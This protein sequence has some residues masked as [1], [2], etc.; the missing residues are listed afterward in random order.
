MTMK[1]I[2]TLGILSLALF[3]FTACNEGANNSTS[4]KSQANDSASAQKQDTKGSK[5]CQ[6]NGKCGEGK[7]ANG[8]KNP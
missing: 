4:Q 8:K 6:A 2:L 1:K 5:K 7:C 3:S